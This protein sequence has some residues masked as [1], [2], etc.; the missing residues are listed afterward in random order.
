MRLTYVRVSNDP[1]A[2][3]GRE[4]QTTFGRLGADEVNPNDR[5][6]ALLLKT[7]FDFQ[8]RPDDVK[9]ALAVSES[10]GS[11]SLSMCVCVCERERDLR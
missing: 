6:P 2:L 3:V 11:G 7:R 10:L 4:S 8:N 1:P 9:D 5:S